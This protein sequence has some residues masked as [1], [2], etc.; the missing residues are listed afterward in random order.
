MT[1]VLMVDV[2]SSVEGIDGK[3]RDK[4]KAFADA[5]REA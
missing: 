5:V 4:I 3:D 1:V 2:S